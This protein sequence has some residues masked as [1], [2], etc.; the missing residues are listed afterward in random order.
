MDW[1]LI[2]PPNPNRR[3]CNSN[4]LGYLL[5]RVRQEKKAIFLGPY[6]WWIISGCRVGKFAYPKSIRIVVDPLFCRLG[7]YSGIGSYGVVI[8]NKEKK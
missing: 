1:I 4:E 6:H 2:T 8:F 5:S 7:L 3:V